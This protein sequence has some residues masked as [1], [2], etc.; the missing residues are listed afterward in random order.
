[1]KKEEIK[2]YEENPISLLRR[3]CRM[4][5]YGSNSFPELIVNEVARDFYSFA[6]LHLICTMFITTDKKNENIGGIFHRVLDPLGKSELINE[7]DKILS[8]PIGRTTLKQFFRSKRNKLATHGSLSF[9]SQQDSNIDVIINKSN[10]DQYVEAM[11][12]LSLAVF[13][14]DENLKVIEKSK[15][16]KK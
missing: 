6:L 9:S 13:K 7:I 8:L 15:K 1:M 3:H 14:L 11:N 10:L 16:Y 4:F 2:S 5:L 12:Q